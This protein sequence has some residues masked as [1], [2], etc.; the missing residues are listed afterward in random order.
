M[1]S[2]TSKQPNYSASLLP[3][4]IPH[5]YG[6]CTSLSSQGLA[7]KYSTH[8]FPGGWSRGSQQ[9]D[10]FVYPKWGFR[11]PVQLTGKDMKLNEIHP[12]PPLQMPWGW[13]KS[14]NCLIQSGPGDE[15][16]LLN[17]DFRAPRSVNLNFVSGFGFQDII[18]LETLWVFQWD[19]R[20]KMLLGLGFDDLIDLHV[21]FL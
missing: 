4:Y 12:N 2:I 11:V 13:N 17:P 20:V 10:R 8:D 19:I 6:R 5:R 14:W 15:H 7:S 21:V 9:M 3:H 18:E 16:I 1:W